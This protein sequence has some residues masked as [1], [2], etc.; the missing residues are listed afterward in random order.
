M[1]GENLTDI[2]EV[3]RYAGIVSK[4]NREREITSAWGIGAPVCVAKPG[5]I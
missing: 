1:A 3:P 5:S 4:S 2:G